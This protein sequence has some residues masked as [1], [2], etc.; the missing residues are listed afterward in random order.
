ML[1]W[2]MVDRKRDTYREIHIQIGR[3]RRGRKGGISEGETEGGNYGER[4]GG[5]E[6]VR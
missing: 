3:E 2:G 6:G 4:G 5:N 1:L